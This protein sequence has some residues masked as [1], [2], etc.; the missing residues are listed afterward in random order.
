MKP[1]KLALLFP[2]MTEEELQVLADDIKENGLRQHIVTYKGKILDGRNR[3]EACKIAG[4][5]IRTW[6]YKGDEPLELVISANMNRR[7]LS[8][9]QRAA[10]SAE[11]AD[12]KHGGDRSSKRQVCRSEDHQA[13][14]ITQKQAAK[15]L[16]VSERS[17]RTARHVLDKGVPELV[18][19]VK[20]GDVSVSDAAS[21]SDAPEEEQREA[22]AAVKSGKARTLAQAAGPKKPRKSKMT[23]CPHCGAVL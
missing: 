6:E 13:Q 16:N 14:A 11:I 7:H 9:S 19:A 10:I 12:I 17:V 4:A 23:V 1:H 21:I 2:P 20:S 5:R 3:Y 15:M 8:E 22:I 18:A